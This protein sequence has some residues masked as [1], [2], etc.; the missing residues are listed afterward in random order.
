MKASALRRMGKLMSSYILADRTKQDKLWWNE[1][2]RACA[3]IGDPFE[4]RCWSDETAEAQQALRFGKKAKSSWHGGPVIKGTIT[5]EFLDF[6]T[7]AQKPADMEIYNKMT[8]F[9]TVWLGNRLY[10]GHY[11]TEVTISKSVRENRTVIDRVLKEM[12]QFGS[13]HRDL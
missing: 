5:R 4:I 8:P 1:L 9:F 2:V 10:S 3:V 13:V 6:L 11:G 7:G 12:E